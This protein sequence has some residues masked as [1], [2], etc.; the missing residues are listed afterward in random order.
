MIRVTIPAYT[1]ADWPRAEKMQS[2][3]MKNPKMKY[4]LFILQITFNTDQYNARRD[5]TIDKGLPWQT[6]AFYHVNIW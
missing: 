2:K 1:V 5:Q 6:I 3:E 4:R